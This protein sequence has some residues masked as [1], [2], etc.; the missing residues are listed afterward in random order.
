M[1]VVLINA[2]E[3]V[4]SKQQQHKYEQ[5]TLYREA[6]QLLEAD[7]TIMSLQTLV[8]CLFVF[9]DLFYIV[10]FPVLCAI[11]TRDISCALSTF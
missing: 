7:F 6:L 3:S 11:L 9:F 4:R 5:M 1:N 10:G 8:F 2:S